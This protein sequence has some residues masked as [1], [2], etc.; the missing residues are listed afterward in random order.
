ML[1]VAVHRLTWTV[2]CHS[3]VQ[4]KLQQR[5]GRIEVFQPEPVVGQEQAVQQVE[6]AVEQVERA[7]GQVGQLVVAGDQL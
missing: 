6:W 5:S 7:A 4:Q 3:W 2:V 1:R